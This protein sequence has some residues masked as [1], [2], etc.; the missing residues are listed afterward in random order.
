MA[1]IKERIKSSR[2]KVCKSEPTKIKMIPT[3]YTASSLCIII[4]NETKKLWLYLLL[5]LN[6]SVLNWPL[7]AN[8]WPAKMGYAQAFFYIPLIAIC[9]LSANRYSGINVSPMPKL[10]FVGRLL[11]GPLIL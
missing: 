9:E 6:R 2:F 3:Y 5:R 1:S 11:L 7:F 10:L 4:Y 8:L